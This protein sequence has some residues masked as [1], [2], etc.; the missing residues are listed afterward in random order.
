MQ[1]V[2]VPYLLAKKYVS[3]A[4]ET[5]LRFSST[6]VPLGDGLN[7]TP[8]CSDGQRWVG[9]LDKVSFNDYNEQV[10]YRRYLH[11]PWSMFRFDA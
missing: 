4:L 8:V 6:Q 5:F 3:N 2:C 7:A 9:Q 1:L 11:H 10:I